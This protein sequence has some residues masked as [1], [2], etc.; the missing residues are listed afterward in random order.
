MDCPDNESRT[1]AFRIGALRALTDMSRLEW[2]WNDGGYGYFYA[3]IR[4]AGA[5]EWAGTL[6]Q[7]VIRLGECEE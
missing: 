7:A 2:G 1:C 3:P 6:E 4:G 5:T